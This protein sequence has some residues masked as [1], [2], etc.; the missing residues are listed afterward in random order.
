MQFY[1][2]SHHNVSVTNVYKLK[3]KQIK[4]RNIT[5]IISAVDP[6]PQVLTF[7]HQKIKWIRDQNS[8]FYFSMTVLFTINANFIWSYNVE[9]DSFSK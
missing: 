1:Y 5:Q 4:K 3:H 7:H 2:F 9:S 8:E 6:N